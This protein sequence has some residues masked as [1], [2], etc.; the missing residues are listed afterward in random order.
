VPHRPTRGFIA[1]SCPRAF[2]SS[3]K[4][5]KAIRHAIQGKPHGRWGYSTRAYRPACVKYRP[6]QDLLD[7]I[8]DDVR[9][10]KEGGRM[11]QVAAFIAFVMLFIAVFVL[12]LVVGVAGH[13]GR[14]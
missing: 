5:S 11:V 6:F 14:P 13:Q 10:H 4:Q 8:R 9:Q 2:H 1:P 12:A 3:V 7:C